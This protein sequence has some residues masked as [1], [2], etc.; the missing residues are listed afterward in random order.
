[1][2]SHRQ[3]GGA[4]RPA[5]LVPR[6]RLLAGLLTLPLTALMR[7]VSAQTL[8][9]FQ[10]VPDLLDLPAPP[11]PSLPLAVT[12]AGSR[13]VTVGSNGAIQLSDDDGRIWRAAQSVPVSVTLTDIAFIDDRRGWAIGHGGVLLLTQ[14]GGEHWQRRM[15]GLDAAQLALTEAQN[16]SPQ[17][18]RNAQGLVQDGPDKPFLCLRFIDAQ[19]GWA[20]GAYGLALLTRDGGQSWQSVMTRLPNDGGKHLYGLTQ[21]ASGL[22]IVGEQGSVFH[23]ATG[24]TGFAAIETPYEGTFF[25]ALP[26]VDGGALAFGLRG[27]LWRSTP[28]LADW[29]KIALPDDI[30]LTTGLRLNDGTLLLGNE[31]GQLRRSQ[32]DGRSFTRLAVSL[33]AG[34]TGLW[35]SRSGAVIATGA[36]GVRRLPPQDL[37]QEAH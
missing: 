28:D 13:L 4:S 30:T 37:M 33:P 15:T 35:Q 32:D 31:A 26:L 11:G 19:T 7:P 18:L 10:G 8:P 9:A 34:L 20:V 27:N 21:L 36:G 29:Q 23:Q 22:L 24:T 16:A 17:A 25:G 5:G 14:D 2:V 6:R 3:T 12:Q 1:M